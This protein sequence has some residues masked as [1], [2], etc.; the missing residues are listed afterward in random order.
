M[1]H[2]DKVQ[3]LI[4]GHFHPMTISKLIAAVINAMSAVGM[5]VVVSIWNESPTIFPLKGFG[6]TEILEHDQNCSR[7]HRVMS[8]IFSISIPV[9]KM[10]C[11]YPLSMPVGLKS[12]SMTKMKWCGEVL[13]NTDWKI[14]VEQWPGLII[15]LYS[16]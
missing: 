3:R 11:C 8:L 5:K 6:E 4:Q 12:E 16:N 13:M 10:R 7:I 15:K 14:F 2:S 9:G 1:I